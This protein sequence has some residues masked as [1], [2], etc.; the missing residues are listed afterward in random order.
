MGLH[1]FDIPAMNALWQKIEG[2]RSLNREARPP[3]ENLVFE[4]GGVRGLV[5]L[6]ALNVLE[7]NNLLNDVKRVA[8]SSVGGIVSMLLA[9]GY[10][11]TEIEELMKIELDF[12]KLMDPRVAVDPTRFFK[13]AGMEIGALDIAML[14]KHKGMYKG[15]AFVALTKLLISRKIE[16]KLQFVLEQNKIDYQ[17]YLISHGI[18]DLT[19]ITFAQLNDLNEK[20]PALNFKSLYLTGTRLSD[21]SL[22]EF[23]HESTPDMAVVDA[24]RITMSFP[25]GF[26]PVHYQ[27]DYYVDGGVAN[28]YP[29]GIFDKDQFLSHGLNAAKVNPCTLGLVVDTREEIAARWGMQTKKD[30]KL[31]NV[32]GIAGTI[33]EGMIT[34]MDFLKNYYDINSVQIVDE[35]IDTMDL[36]LSEPQK[37]KLIASGRHMMQHFV[38]CYMGNDLLYDNLPTYQNLTEKYYSKHPQELKKIIEEDLWP[39]LQEVHSYHCALENTDLNRELFQVKEKLAEYPEQELAFQT[40]IYCQSQ[41]IAVMVESLEMEE[42]LLSEKIKSIEI[43]KRRLWERMDNKSLATASSSIKAQWLS[44]GEKLIKEVNELKNKRRNI[45][46][47]ISQ[48]RDKVKKLKYAINKECYELLAQQ[49]ITVFLMES[50]MIEKLKETENILHEQMDLILNA[51]A[52]SQK[53]Y[54]D[55]RISDKRE[56]ITQS[57]KHPK[58]PVQKIN[59]DYQYSQSLQ[60]LMNKLRVG[61]WGD[62]VQFSNRE[63]IEHNLH[64]MKIK[65]GQTYGKHESAYRVF[66]IHK[67]PLETKNYFSYQQEYPLPPIK[68]HLLSPKKQSSNENEIILLF[69]PPSSPDEEAFGLMSKHTDD[70]EQIFNRYKNE[71][72]KKLRL[73]LAQ[74]VGASKITI[75]GEG[76]AGQDAQYMFSALIDELLDNGNVEE[77][78]KINSIE[79]MLQDPT[80]VSS[81]LAISTAQKMKKLKNEKPLITVK[82][83]NLIHQHTLAGKVVRNRSQNYLGQENILSHVAPSDAHVV[84]EFRDYADPNWLLN[85]ISNRTQPELVSKKLNK[86]NILYT[87][88]LFSNF[89]NYGHKLINLG[90]SLLMGVF[91]RLMNFFISLPL[92]VGKKILR[93][94]T[95]PISS[96]YHFFRK[97]KPLKYKIPS[98]S[99][100]IN[101]NTVDDKAKNQSWEEQAHSLISKSRIELRLIRENRPPIENLVFE[102]GGVKG[103]AYA[104]ALQKME[105][106]GLFN[107]VKRVAGSS[108]GGMTAALLAMG[109]TA[110]ELKDLLTHQ[111][112]FNDLKDSIVSLGGIKWGGLDLYALYKHKGLY[113]G[114]SFQNQMENLFKLKLESKLKEFFFQQLTE[115][116]RQRLMSVPANLSAKERDKRIDYF[117]QSKLDQ[118]LSEQ[119]ISDLGKITFGQLEAISLIFPQLA[120][121]EL[122]ITGTKLSDGNLA[123]FCAENEP[124][125]PIIQAVRITMSYPGAFVPVEYNGEYYIDGGVANNYPM[126]IFDHEKFLTHG[127]NDAKVNPCTLGLLIDSQEEIDARWGVKKEIDSSLTINQFVRKILKSLRNRSEILRDS[128]NINSIQIHDAGVKTMDFNLSRKAKSQL[129]QNG[130]EAMAF[131]AKNYCEPDVT[132]SH[133]ESY[134][135]FAQKYYSKSYLELKRILED[136]IY[137]LLRSYDEIRSTLNEQFISLQHKSRQLSAQLKGFDEPIH[138][139]EKLYALEYEAN[140]LE[141]H[142]VNMDIG[143]LNAKKQL[144]VEEQRRC[145]QI[146]KHTDQNIIPKIYEKVNID[147]NLRLIKQV[148][149]SNELI[150][151]EM[152]IIIS[153]MKSKGVNIDKKEIIEIGTPNNA[154]TFNQ[155]ITP[156]AVK[157]KGKYAKVQKPFNK[158]R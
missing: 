58:S 70:R 111:I 155:S 119:K 60:T 142:N 110:L 9:V 18:D 103:I 98:W 3:I 153:A 29:M 34:R 94:I 35:D 105:N 117:L 124:D 22:C 136:E 128:Y 100:K 145:Y 87:G 113:K 39:M 109:Y 21:A 17:K 19:E 146:L 154:I 41:E 55:P 51:L 48:E 33:L 5:Y 131:Y 143:K 72:I 8:G 83:H 31:E 32:L 157:E 106:E 85:K 107:D 49:Q 127:I 152:H 64:S 97:K 141:P 20:F 46:L 148:K 43:Q 114:D 150:Q 158:Y 116:E 36:L 101:V 69:E 44:Q 126:Q 130:Q 71:F 57:L 6:G 121:K 129:I 151:Q 137:P 23:S 47:Q 4:G 86:N 75:F 52:V 78:E 156:N 56:V 14:F 81:Q 26:E 123:V 42:N 96:I 135:N 88:K 115:N 11:P 7:E 99:T 102:G 76:L 104:G 147:S 149:R 134:D 40:K 68:L 10:T 53:N 67:N 84:A 27:G 74:S 1:Q 63:D 62:H 25:F 16:E 138:I 54:L 80:R 12:K 82:G 24:V 28:N 91:P 45:D 120:I 15:D 139:I 2:V 59:S 79:L 73:A 132:Y 140:Q 108:C 50:K 38:D 13:I 133:L 30:G 95:S 92:H 122:Y 90:R 65:Q 118:F 66:T 37:N 93:K 61:K 89:Y 77:L 112:N 144:I 125:M